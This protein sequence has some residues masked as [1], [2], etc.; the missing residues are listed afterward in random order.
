MGKEFRKLSD[1]FKHI[2]KKSNE[3]LQN[4]EEVKDVMIEETV[5]QIETNVYEAYKSPAANPYQRKKD[6]G[7]LTDPENFD[8]QPAPNGVLFFSTRYDKDTDTYIPAV[9]AGKQPYSIPDRWGYGYEE[10]RYFITPT[11]EELLQNNRHIIAFKES[12]K[13]SGFKIE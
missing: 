13:K 10:P 9:L 12:M 11:V 7:G 6:E 3:V 2:E 5:Q 1:L 8:Y 4:S